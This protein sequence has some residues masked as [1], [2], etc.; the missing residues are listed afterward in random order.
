M[1]NSI[2]PSTDHKIIIKGKTAK[3][4][5]ADPEKITQVI[6]NLINNAIKYSKNNQPIIIHLEQQADNAKVSVQ[7]FGVGIASSQQKRIFEQFYQVK[8]A[9][10]KPSSGLGIGL[11]ICQQI[12]INHQGEIGV[13][14]QPGQGSIFWFTLPGTKPEP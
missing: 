10:A 5:W 12:I 13:E 7:D 14:S 8:K 9:A 11:Y 1:V 6:T 3:Q 4:V 2:K